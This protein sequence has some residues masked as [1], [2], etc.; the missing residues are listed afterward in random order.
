MEA[1]ANA[2]VGGLTPAGTKANRPRLSIQTHS[3]RLLPLRSDADR[4]REAEDRHSDHKGSSRHGGGD[5]PLSSTMRHDRFW[6]D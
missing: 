1:E 6:P 2:G 3:L 5:L 4:P